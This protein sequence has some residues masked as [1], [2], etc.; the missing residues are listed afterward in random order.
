M[1]RVKWSSSF[2][3]ML[4]G[5]MIGGMVM[6]SSAAGKGKQPKQAA[7]DFT[8]G[9]QKDESHDWNLGPTGARGWFY[10]WAGNTS[11]ARQ[12]LVTAV[13]KGSPADGILQSGDVILGVGE[14]GFDTDAR[15][16]FANAI[17]VAEQGKAM[18]S[19]G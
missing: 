13:D 1:Q 11:E 19:C 2:S 15:I 4:S 7:P 16:Q 3:I 9:G 18:A 10:G 5:L 17:A 6:I 8:K 14:K 12:I